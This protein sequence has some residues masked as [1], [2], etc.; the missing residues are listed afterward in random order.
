MNRSTYLI[1]GFIGIE[2]SNPTLASAISNINP[3]ITFI[4]AIIFRFYF[5]P[6][7]FFSYNYE[8]LISNVR[9]FLPINKKK[10]K[11]FCFSLISI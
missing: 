6:F 3:A 9:N 2:Y 5:N 10:Y 1:T 4:L 8:L 11:N 7:T